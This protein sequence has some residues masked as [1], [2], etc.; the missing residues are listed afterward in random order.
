[1]LQRIT[2]LSILMLL[3]ASVSQGQETWSLERCI[4]YAQQNSLTMKQADYT[5]QDAQLNL[6][7][8]QFSRLPSINASVN[9]GYQFGRTID[10]TTNTFNTE[11]II[12]NSYNLTT[13]LPLFTGFQIVNSVK[14]S[15]YDLAASQLEA[16]ASANDMA[17][18]IATAYLNILL[19][20][21]Q[22][23]NARN[24]LGQSEEQLENTDKLIQAGSLPV[25]DRLDFVAQVARDEQA[26]VE[27]ENAVIVNYLTLKQLMEVDPNLDFKIERPDALVIPS[28]RDPENFNVN[29]IFAAALGAQPQI[30][31]G[32]QRLQ[33]ALMGVDIARASMLPTVSLFGNLNTNYSS[34]AQTL[35]GTQTVRVEQTFFID[36]NPVAVA[37]DQEVPNFEDQSYIDQ[38]NENFGQNF[39]LSIQV[40]IYNRHQN[41]IAMDRSR[42]QA[43]NQEVLNRQQRQQLKT[44]VQR[45]V[46][47]AR[48]AQ[49]SLE[50]AQR[51][52]EAAQGAY[53]NA[54]RRFDLGAINSLEF[55]TARNTLE[56]A[57]VS[58][59]Q[60]KYQFVFNVKTVDFYLGRPLRMD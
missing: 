5:I 22:L 40:P 57:K 49:R 20:E 55:T 52:L 34:L 35:S 14:Q 29:E 6:K 12:F 51:T 26:I 28:D 16:Q 9:G 50:A 44:D 13:N 47:D 7:R 45:A 48:A 23:A 4:E 10:P 8:N 25:N 46:A 3:S 1:M 17:L 18:Q 58:L 11:T 60:A 42:V 38:V 30:E 56:Q 32:N 37:F 53:E 21:E 24:R 59:I 41:R 27:A 36:D 54:Q 43:L 39:G 19:A 2:L 33:S 31:A 15:K